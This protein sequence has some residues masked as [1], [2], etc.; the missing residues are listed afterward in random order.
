MTPRIILIYLTT[1]AFRQ[2]AKILHSGLY[3]DTHLARS[4]VSLRIRIRSIL[5]E[6]TAHSTA[7]DATASDVLS[8]CTA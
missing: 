2:H 3:L 4:P 1:L 8:G 5:L 7:A 6:Y